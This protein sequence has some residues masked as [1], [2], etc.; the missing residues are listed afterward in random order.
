MATWCETFKF[1]NEIFTTVAR[2][3]HRLFIT[4]VAYKVIITY[5]VCYFTL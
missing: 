4:K 3:Q 5:F 2:E 1:N